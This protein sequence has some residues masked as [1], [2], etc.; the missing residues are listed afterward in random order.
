[1]LMNQASADCSY[2]RLINCQTGLAL[3]FILQ[4]RI[5]GKFRPHAQIAACS[6][7]SNSDEDPTGVAF[8]FDELHTNLG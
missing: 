7:H 5:G 8:R 1:M 3:T 6:Q 4:R 2:W